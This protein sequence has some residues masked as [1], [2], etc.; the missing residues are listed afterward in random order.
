MPLIL[1]SENFMTPEA[2]R[3]SAEAVKQFIKKLK[4]H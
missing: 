4:S 3:V 1:L 2:V